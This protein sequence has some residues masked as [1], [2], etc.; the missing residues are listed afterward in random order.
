MPYVPKNRL[1]P[2]R[3]NLRK[4]YP[5]LN[6]V[7]SRHDQTKQF[8]YYAPK[9]YR[10]I[11]IHA[12][13]FK[14]PRKFREEYETAKRGE[15]KPDAEPSRRSRVGTWNAAID[16]YL[17]TGKYTN[18]APNTKRLYRPF[19]E[20]LR[21]SV[22]SRLMKQTD[23]WDIFQLHD[24]VAKSSS[25]Q[26]NTF[27]SVLANI[28]HVGRL[29]RWV[30]ADLD[31]LLGIEHQERDSTSYRPYTDD[32]VAA[33]RDKHKLGTMA[34]AAFELAYGL[35]LGNADLIRL[36]P[37]HIDDLG[38][39]W[40]ARKKTATTQTSNINLDPTLRQV[41]AAF[42]PPPVDGP[43]DMAGRSTVPYLRNY[44]GKPFDPD[45]STFRKQWRRWAAEAGLPADFKIHGARATMVTDMM[46]AGVA[47]S[48]GMRRTGHL[49][50]RTYV[51]VYGK[52]ASVTRA[53]TRAQERVV[54][55]RARKSGTVDKALRA[56]A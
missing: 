24:E 55:A 22:G 52:E 29:R 35:A 28:I 15:P 54:T 3:A 10:P 46:D 38:N 21:A 19:I 43:V 50:E 4:T 2:E 45:G 32:E 56:V 33:W 51:R 26:A 36:A 6:I 23:P 44:Y 47:N 31:L 8:I 1:G 14:E 49:D 7:R 20:A 25:A 18:K 48:D 42:P 30:P 53:A 37:C 5:G 27:L 17:T 11:R 39:V 9:G 13:P 16:D 12:D 40:I 41:F 34:L